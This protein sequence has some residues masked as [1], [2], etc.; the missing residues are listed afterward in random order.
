MSFSGNRYGAARPGLH[1]VGSYQVSGQPFLTGSN[2]SGSENMLIR[3]TE[4]CVAFPYV[5]KSVT[6]WNY[7]SSSLGKLRIHMVSSGTIA[8]HPTSRHYV[9]LSQSEGYTLNAKCNSIWLSAV[10][11][12]IN[13]KLYASLTNIPSGSMYELSGSGINI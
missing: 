13:W 12:E 6:V 3:G 4:K 10:G 2:I 8:N 1:N 11:A 9:E 5:A 7:S